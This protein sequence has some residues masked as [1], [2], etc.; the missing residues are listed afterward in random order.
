A[1]LL[2]G[3]GVLQ[4]P[5]SSAVIADS[6]SPENRAMG[7]ATMNSISGL[8]AIVAPYV[9]GLTIDALGEEM[10]IR[11]LYAVLMMVYLASATINL[12]FL[13]DTL[14]S[15][16]QR[17]QL[18]DL[19]Q[20]VKDVYA[21]IPDILR[22]LPRSLNVLAIVL[23]LSFM[24]NA[25]AGPF[26]V[27]YASRQIGL[28]STRWGLILFVETALRNLVYIPAGI[29]VDRCGRSR[30]I[31]VALF[32]SLVAIPLFVLAEAF[33]QVLLIRS[34]VGIVN[35]FFVPACSALMADLVPRDLRGRVMA[36][37][38]R[39]SVMIGASS[40]GTGGPGVGFL[41]TLPIMLSSLAGGYLYDWNPAYP[42]LFVLAATL[43]SLLLA[44][45]FVRDPEKA[46]P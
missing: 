5:A 20:A 26:W 45:F 35:A 2:Q 8:L 43:I 6:L 25:I 4:F 9:A 36:A 38:G 40:G 31:R 37:L 23:T 13:R 41:M 21:D 32:L 19:P 16:P 17:M 27:V 44:I 12:H 29:M 1:G 15:S 30:S 39:G 11:L 3:F 22:C 10:G 46:E 34:V 18:A 14:S 7:M 24:A 33:L 42:W 28:S